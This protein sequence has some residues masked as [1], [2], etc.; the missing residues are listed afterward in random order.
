ME[1]LSDSPWPTCNAELHT[2]LFDDV[3][4]LRCALPFGH[5]LDGEPEHHDPVLRVRWSV[6][7]TQ[8]EVDS[9]DIED[10]RE[11]ADE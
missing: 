10:W 3:G 5:H 6:T 1:P 2:K 11:T 8:P 9:W 7:F 4:P